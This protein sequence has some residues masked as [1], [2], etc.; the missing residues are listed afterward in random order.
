MTSPEDI[1]KVLSSSVNI[2]KSFS[3]H[4]LH[5]WLGTGLVTSTGQKWQ[6]RRKILTPAFHFNILKS[7]SNV[8]IR[9]TEELV[10]KLDLE[11]SKPFTNVSQLIYECTIKII[12]ETAMCTKF[13]NDNRDNEEY[14]KNVHRMGVI[15]TKRL[16]RPWLYPQIFYCLTEMY[17]MERNAVKV[18]HEITTRMIRKRLNEF[19]LSS[20]IVKEEQPEETCSGKLRQPMLDLLIKLMVENGNIDEHGIREEVDTFMFG[21]HDTVA[22]SLGFSL[23]LLACHQEI[24]NRVREEVLEVFGNANNKITFKDLQGLSY[25]EMFIKESLRLYPSVPQISRRLDEPITTASGFY[26]P[27]DTEV[28]IHIVDLHL[29]EE[30]WPDPYRFDPDRFLPEATKHRH[31]FAYIPFSAGP[32]NCI[33]Q[34]FAMLEMKAILAG[35]VRS[36]RLTA[37]DTPDTLIHVADFVSRTKNEIKVKFERL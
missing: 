29:N 1:E 31:P 6:N 25:M 23:M 32:R 18:L 8:F 5:N 13:D 26:L 28:Y 9:Q 10:K 24:Q 36:F 33:G 3:Y 37:V 20:N 14:M 15:S 7:F 19:R 17:R 11:C 12:A 16:L 22:T 30:L 27:K 35:V 34:K 4:L 21:G 2:D